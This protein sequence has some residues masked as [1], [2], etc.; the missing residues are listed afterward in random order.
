MV[1]KLDVFLTVG[2][3]PNLSVA[4]IVKKMGK[5]QIT[6][7]AVLK[8]SLVLRG[9]ILIAERNG[10]LSIIK[11]KKSQTLFNMVYFCFKNNIDYNKVVAEKTA[12]FVKVGLEKGK[13]SGMIFDAK[14]VR[15]ITTPLSI[16]G[17]VIVETKKPF[18]CKIVPSQFTTELV[19][20]FFD[21]IKPAYFNIVDA[22][23]E[24][25]V[26]L[27]LEKAYSEYK[28]LEKSKLSFDEVKKLKAKI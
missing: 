9:E 7:N 22:L 10:L 26:D 1:S 12:E 27:K 28:R 20:Y 17:F 2:I 19:T 16:N 21:S 11:D 24:Y 8:H 6:Y 4:E 3:Y 14:T 15:R 25:T 5:K 13:I 18:L 23:D